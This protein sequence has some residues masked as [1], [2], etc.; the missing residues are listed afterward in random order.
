MG[1]AC[2]TDGRDE[3]F[4]QYFV[5]KSEENRPFG[6]PRR[7]WEDTIRMNRKET[8]WEVVN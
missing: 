2:S 7:R 3:K 1:G 4:M 5:G 8:G 6:R